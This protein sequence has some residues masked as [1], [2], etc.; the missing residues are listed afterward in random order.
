MTAFVYGDNVDTDVI[1]LARYLNDASPKNLAAHCM[2][3][4]DRDFAS[5]VRPGDIIV[6]GANFGCGSFRE[7][8]PLAIKA[9]GVSVVVVKSFAR[10][11]FRNAINIGLPIIEC[12]EITGQ[13]VRVMEAAGKLSGISFSFQTALMGGCAVDK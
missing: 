9:C 3:D 1:I 6:A 7:Q 2:E 11:F 5:K 10:I 12:P 8:A 4:I 13:A